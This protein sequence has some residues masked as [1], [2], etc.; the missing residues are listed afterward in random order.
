MRVKTQARRG[1]QQSAFDAKS[2]T[3]NL[4]E[5]AMNIAA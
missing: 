3:A 1:I 4:D 5:K 2:A